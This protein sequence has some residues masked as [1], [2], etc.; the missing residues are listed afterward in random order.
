MGYFL[1][2]RTKRNNRKDFIVFL[3]LPP[4]NFFSAYKPAKNASFFSIVDF[5]FNQLSLNCF[6]T[7]KYHPDAI[8][9]TDAQAEEARTKFLEVQEAYNTLKEEEVC[10]LEYKSENG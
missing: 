4:A 8:Q 7:Y 10:F 1:D 2:R 6:F 9:S 3:H 5:Q